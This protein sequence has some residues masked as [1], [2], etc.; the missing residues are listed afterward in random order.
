MPISPLCPGVF[1]RER[2][3]YTLMSLDAAQRMLSIMSN[4]SQ[5]ALTSTVHALGPAPVVLLHD[6]CL[7]ILVGAHEAGVMTSNVLV[8][9]WRCPVLIVSQQRHPGPPS[10]HPGPA[11]LELLI[12]TRPGRI[13]GSC[14]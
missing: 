3:G 2:L 5:E 12:Q 1:A 4:L 6:S 13:F 9:L 7:K 14:T 10:M 8:A 11:C